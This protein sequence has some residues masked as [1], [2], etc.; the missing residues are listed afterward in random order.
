MLHVLTLNPAGTVLELGAT[1]WGL[2]ATKKI[3]VRACYHEYATLI[4][5]WL[6]NPEGGEALLAGTKG[7]GKSVF[8]LLLILLLLRQGKIVFYH[9]R[10]ARMML[11]G[12]EATADQ[13]A[14]VIEQLSLNGF[15]TEFGAGVYRFEDPSDVALFDKLITVEGLTHVLDLGEDPPPMNINGTSRKVVISSPNTA[16]LRHFMEERSGLKKFYMPPWSLDE[17]EEHRVALGITDP[18]DLEERF[19]IFGGIIRHVVALERETGE[20]TMARALADAKP[21]DISRVLSVSFESLSKSDLRSCLI[22]TVPLDDN[23]NRSK[24]VFASQWVARNLLRR[25]RKENAF[26]LKAFIEGCSGLRAAS[27]MRGVLIEQA[28]HEAMVKGGAAF[29]LADLEARK[30]QFAAMSP[31]PALAEVDFEG[32]TLD[33]LKRDFK[34]LEYALPLAPNFEAVDCFAVLPRDVFVKKAKGVCL[35]AFQVTAARTHDVTV[36]GL[37]RVYD[38]VLSRL[39]AK[40][41]AEVKSGSMYLVFITDKTGVYEKQRIKAKRGEAKLPFDV[42]QYCMCTASVTDDIAKLIA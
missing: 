23:I 39:G 33:G 18:V 30:P 35:A 1:L 12:P 36:T 3:V 34:P 22:H 31:L 42:H 19:T 25:F 29:T 41:K 28:T 21:A 13:K 7:I 11:V 10:G 14:P 38:G 24:N 15:A 40:L 20:D 26:Q 32:Q 16:K 6:D 4:I 8:G 37:R 17:F 27:A 9:H 5:A 2:H